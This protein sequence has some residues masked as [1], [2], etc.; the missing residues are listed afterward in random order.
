MEGSPACRSGLLASV[1]AGWI[2]SCGLAF[3]EKQAKAAFDDGACLRFDRGGV[4]LGARDRAVVRAAPGVGV[5]AEAIGDL[6]Q[7]RTF[8]R[9]ELEDR[10]AG[11]EIIMRAAQE[12]GNQALQVG[13][14]GLARERCKRS[15]QRRLFTIR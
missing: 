7:V 13:A 8:A 14:S 6:F 2:G 15:P 3:P 12:L 9:P 10:L 5:V 4:A 1:G 11:E